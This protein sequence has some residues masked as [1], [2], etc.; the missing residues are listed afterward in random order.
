MGFTWLL[1]YESVISKAKKVEY[2]VRMYTL[3]S[4]QNIYYQKV[5]RGKNILFLHGWKQDSSS[6]WNLIDSLKKDFSVWLIDLPGFGRSDNPV[7]PFTVSGYADLIAGF[8]AQQKIKDP[9]VLGHSVG[10]RIAIKLAANYPQLLNKLI[11]EDA[12]G[13]RPKRDIPKTFI[14]P[15]AKIIHYLIPNWFNLKERLRYKFYKALESDYID[16]G[17]LKQTFTNVLNEDLAVDLPKIKTETLLIWGEKDPTLEASLANGKKMYR[18]IPNSR[19]EVID[20]VG[21]FPHLQNPERFLYYVK[22]FC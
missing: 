8:I 20:D 6:F 19:I 18:L 12:A 14:Y 15:F 5:G 11:L 16:V 1:Y 10:G 7:R 13:I 22:D 2:P 4:G 17:E 21:H 9:I 3:V